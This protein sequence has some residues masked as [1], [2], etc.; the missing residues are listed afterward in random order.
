MNARPDYRSDIDGLRAV[1][2]LGVLVYHYGATW[3]PGGFTG[4]DVFFVISGFLITSILRR[5]I[6]AGEFSLLGFYDRRLRRIAP[7]LF[8]VLLVSLVA[9]WFLLIPGDYADMAKSAAYSAGGLGN[10]Y[11]FWNTGYFDQA[12]DLQ[13]MLHMWSLGV[14]EQFYFVWPPLL[15]LLMTRLS[16]QRV[17]VGV[18]AIGL[19]VAFAFAVWDVSVHPKAAFYLPHARAWEL[20]LGAILAFLPRIGNRL[21]SEVMVAAGLALIAWSYLVITSKDPFPGLNAAY[22]CIGAALVIWPKSPT[23]FA[24][25]LS[26]RPMVWVGLISYSLYLWH[27]PSWS[28]SATTPT[29]RCRTRRPPSVSVCSR[30]SLPPCRGALSSGPFASLWH[31]RRAPWRPAW[32]SPVAWRRSRCPWSRWEALSQGSPRIRRA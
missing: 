2:V 8:A 6:L 26:L 12:A 10:L 20:A 14:E 15:F 18:L 31:R 4:V 13:P 23:F 21:L 19:A 28:S 22:A 30:S 24:G 27:W 7:A 17:V 29:A 11:F 25:P 16:S 32:R 9:G 3:L 1:A 5:E